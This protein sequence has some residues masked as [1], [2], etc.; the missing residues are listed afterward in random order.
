MTEKFQSVELAVQFSDIR[1]VATMDGKDVIVKHVKGGL[2]KFEREYGSNI[3]THT[4]YIGGTEVEIPWPDPEIEE[5]APQADDTMRIDVEDET[6]L[7]SIF[8]SPMPEGAENELI[9]QHSTK[10][11]ATDKTWLQRKIVEDARSLWYEERK[12]ATPKELYMKS[13]RKSMG[14]E[15]TDKEKG[16]MMEMIR[17]EQEAVRSRMSSTN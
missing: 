9:N 3:P 13:T 11:K 12:L 15:Q 1:L 14:V 17:K 5:K 10:K 8:Q 4:R 2:P 7:T 6:Y 16:K